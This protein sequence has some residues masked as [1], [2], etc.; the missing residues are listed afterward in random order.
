M[1]TLILAASALF[2]VSASANVCSQ[3]WDSINANRGLWADFGKVTFQSP[4]DTAGDLF[5]VSVDG[6]CV[7]GAQILTRAPVAVCVERSGG[8]DPRCV[9]E[10]QVN[11][12]TDINY[13]KDVPAGN[14][15]SSEFVS[16]PF[17]IETTMSVPV[18]L[19]N[20]EFF[21]ELCQ[22]EFTIPAC[23]Q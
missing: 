15:D 18:G 17:T 21:Q 16:L 14:G 20:G 7:S 4:A 2:A 6:V 19:Q 13:V 12:A 5:Q 23:G 1:K 11:L 10:V 9:S 8:E 22:K 3:S